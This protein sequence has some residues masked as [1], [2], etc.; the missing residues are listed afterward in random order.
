MYIYHMPAVTT[1]LFDLGNVII[2]IDIPGA[3]SRLE[4]LIKK[5]YD[6]SAARRNMTDL[7]IAL[8]TGQIAPEAFTEGM[9]EM[10]RADVT[11]TDIEDTWNSMLIGIPRYRLAMLEALKANYGVYLLSNTNYFHLTWVHAHLL[12]SHGVSD[13]DSRYFND[14]YYSHLIQRRKPDRDAF[15]YVI[16]DSFLTPG[17][18]LFIDDMPDNI[19]TAKRLGFQTHLS[20]PEEEIAEFLKVNNYY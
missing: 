19:A 4:S 10:S 7:V 16:E 8:E 17:Q 11:A 20:P 12:G 13:F 15:E 1:L 9:L 6:L 5:G 18:T 14:V 3:T 2:D